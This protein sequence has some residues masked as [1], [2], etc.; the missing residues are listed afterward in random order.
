MR[1]GNWGDTAEAKR[2]ILESIER[3][4]QAQKG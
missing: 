4:K 2:I 3:E 1:V